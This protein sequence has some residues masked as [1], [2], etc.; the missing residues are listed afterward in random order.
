MSQA[1]TPPASLPGNVPTRSVT[2]MT[3]QDSD[4]TSRGTPA[5]DP[6][7]LPP[8]DGSTAERAS[9]WERLRRARVPQLLGVYAGA[10]FG[11]LQVADIFMNRLGLPDWT[12]FGLL[13][14]LVAGVPVVVVTAMAQ[15]GE[16]SLRTKALFSWKNTS[17]AGLTA[18]TAL[19]LAVGGFM[20]ARA[21][22]IGPV[23][24]LVAA[25]VIDRD[26]AI[27]I[28]DFQSPTGDSLLAGAITEAFRIDFEQSPLVRVVSPGAVRDGL[29]RMGQQPDDPLTPALARELA[30][31]EGIKALIL[32][33]INRVGGGSI[34][35]VRL[36]SPDSE[37]AIVSFRETISDDSEIIGAVDRLSSRLRER[38]GES[39]R[40]IRGSEPLEQVTT[41]SLAALRRYSQAVRALDLERDIESGI[42]YLEQAIAEDSTFAMAWR[43]L[44]V[45]KSNEN[46]PAEEVTHALARAYELSDRLTE[47]E[48]LLTRATYYNAV[49]R[50]QDRAMA[51]YRALLDLYPHE[52]TALNNLA[53]IHVDRG[54]REQAAE[55][56]RRAIQVDSST[57]VYYTNL[58][59]QEMALEEWDSAR[60]TLEAFQ[61]RFPGI[62]TADHLLARLIWVSGDYAGAEDRLRQILEH[63]RAQAGDRLEALF[64]LTSLAMLQGRA[65]EAFRRMEEL[66]QVQER[67]GT[68]VGPGQEVQLRA[69]YHLV[70]EQDTAQ[71][72]RV[73]QEALSRDLIPDAAAFEGA[74]VEA[75]SFFL[76]AGESELARAWLGDHDRIVGEGAVL[77][78]MG[79][80]RGSLDAIL[81]FEDGDRAEAIA[82]AQRRVREQPDDPDRR[83]GLARFHDLAGAADSAAFQFEAYLNTPVALRVQNE[84]MIHPI[85][86][87]R[88]GELHEELGNRD[89]ARE[90]YLRF[91]ELWREADPPLQ[92]RVQRARDRAAAPGGGG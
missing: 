87:E 62:V 17:Y 13:V 92:P 88:L 78:W 71:A 70:L 34:I 58:A 59:H 40:S 10:G 47:R 25:G 41:P 49:T 85:A 61:R 7:P 1:V 48:R 72:I 22:G 51:T 90:F 28:G 26:E 6:A 4:N 35:S 75:A 8:Q 57:I 37:E 21:L 83:F 64:G 31:R 44:G 24:S 79:E 42:A 50:E 89:R 80:L 23:G 60:R 56:L 3:E 53:V 9:L 45:I 20:A 39:L 68:T 54:E 82:W 36:V 74:H 15:A 27:L 65:Q 76:Q 66:R 63:P 52:T 38:L 2:P 86:L 84:Y 14:V 77:P 91:A 16:R 32:G 18:L 43:K 73:V 69:Y 33:E 19:L 30:L 46:H 11:V 81:R 55:L 29:L 67:M 5:G 12:F